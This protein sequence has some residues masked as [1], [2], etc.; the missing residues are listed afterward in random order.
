M[1]LRFV[2]AGAGDLLLEDMSADGRILVVREDSQDGVVAGSPGSA[3]RDLTLIGNATLAALTGDGRQILFSEFGP[4]QNDVYLRDRDGGEAQRLGTGYAWSLSADDRTAVAITSDKPGLVLLPV[5]T[6]TPQRVP[7]DP[8]EDPSYPFVLPDGQH[9]VFMASEH[10]R[11]DRPWIELLS[12]RDRRALAPEGWR[13]VALSP[14]GRLGIGWA[15]DPGQRRA[16]LIPIA[17]GEPRFLPSIGATDDPIAFSHD[18]SVVYVAVLGD[19]R[20][21]ASIDAVQLETGQRTRWGSIGMADPA[22]LT[23]VSWPQISANGAAY[24]YEYHRHASAL[25]LVSGVR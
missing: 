22:G 11:P 25:F 24:A 6:G 16:V 1:A 15:G 13:L 2:T 7:I 10:G 23:V 18:G 14:D 12:G 4:N 5:G 3:E 8:L 17:G 9:V 19:R 21:P 20:P